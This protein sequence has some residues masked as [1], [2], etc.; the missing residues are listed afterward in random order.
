V[1]ENEMN[2]EEHVQRVKNGNVQTKTNKVEKNVEQIMKKIAKIYIFKEKFGEA[3][4]KL[5][6]VGHFIV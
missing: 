2:V 1:N 5:L 4:T 3:I 6:Y